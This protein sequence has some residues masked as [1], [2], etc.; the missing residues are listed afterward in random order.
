MGR[1][2]QAVEPVEQLAQDDV[3]VERG[4]QQAGG[5]EKD[6]QI[7]SSGLHDAVPSFASTCQ[8]ESAQAAPLRYAFSP[9]HICNIFI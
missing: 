9:M 1:L 6:P 4:V 5:P 8:G 3:D 2:Q 7:R